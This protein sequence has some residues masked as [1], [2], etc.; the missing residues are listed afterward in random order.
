MDWEVGDYALCVRNHSEIKLYCH[1][2]RGKVYKVRELE[3][4]RVGKPILLF[5]LDDR[6]SETNGWGSEYFINLKKRNK[7]SKLEKLIYEIK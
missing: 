1:F 4:V 7:A 5:T 6:G 3:Y 2:T